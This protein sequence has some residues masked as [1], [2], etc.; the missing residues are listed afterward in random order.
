M[1]REDIFFQSSANNHPMLG[2]GEEKLLEGTC[3]KN[4][5]AHKPSTLKYISPVKKI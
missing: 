1:Q 2:V 4:V 5:G 3:R